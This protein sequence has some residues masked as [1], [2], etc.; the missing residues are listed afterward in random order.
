[1]QTW[2]GA[3]RIPQA[4][5][6]L[7]SFVVTTH[8]R[9]HRVALGPHPEVGSG[10]HVPTGLQLNPVQ[11]S[12]DDAQAVVWTA[13]PPPSGPPSARSGVGALPQLHPTPETSQKRA[14]TAPT[15]NQSWCART[16][17]TFASFVTSLFSVSAQTWRPRSKACAGIMLPMN[18]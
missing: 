13:Q 6:L 8:C 18:R 11:Q 3:H 17:T 2:S 10:W 15:M 7:G 14:A 5:Q 9:L 12:A 4:P 16:D 1:V